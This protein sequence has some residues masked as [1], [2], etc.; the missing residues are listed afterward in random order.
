MFGDRLQIAFISS[1]TE[2]TILEMPSNMYFTEVDVVLGQ[3]AT[4]KGKE[5][6]ANFC[7]CRIND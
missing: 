6:P 3:Q 1:K 2:V 5:D 7:E 4:E